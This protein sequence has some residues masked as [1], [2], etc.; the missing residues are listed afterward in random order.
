M[1]KCS[2]Y[3]AGVAVFVALS[4]TNAIAQPATPTVAAAGKTVQSVRPPDFMSLDYEKAP[5][6][7]ASWEVSKGVPADPKV[8]PA[9][10]ISQ[11]SGCTATFVGSRAMLTAAHC[12]EHR[13]VITVH[14]AGRTRELTC[15]HQKEYSKNYDSTPTPENW[16][17][18]SADYALCL[19]AKAD[20]VINV[21]FERVWSGP[22]Q[23]KSGVPV[24]LLGF[25]CSGDSIRSD[26][27]G[28]LRSAVATVTEEPGAKPG[29]NY[30]V[31]YWGDGGFGSAKGG[32]LCPGD[33]GGA[34][35]WP[36][37]PAMNRRIVA[38]N[39]R[40]GIAAGDKL[41][42]YSYLSA[43]FTDSAKSLLEKFEGIPASEAKD[44]RICGLDPQA[45][46]CRP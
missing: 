1:K 2:A 44:I 18:T 39:S 24:L 27:Y 38:V 32:A 6:A 8:W 10:L 16:N 45:E 30:F 7:P 12:V 23:A 33:S 22:N 36:A 46:G 11:P 20:A 26:G 42:G 17:K 3:I 43:T 25:G 31:T 35:Y 9:T 34:A 19:V 13:G 4:A 5:V 14:I 40:T 29:M 41:S 15:Y 21:P 37:D 28:L